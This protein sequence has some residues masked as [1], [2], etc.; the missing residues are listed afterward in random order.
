MTGLNRLYGGAGLETFTFNSF[1]EGSDRIFD[2]NT[3]NE[4]IQVSA[5]GFRGGLSVGVQICL[6]VC[7][8]RPT[9]YHKPTA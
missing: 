3:T 2:F 7:G 5:I 9:M 4:V 1:N 8:L 6:Y